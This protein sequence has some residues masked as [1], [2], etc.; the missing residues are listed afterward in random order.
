VRDD[1]RMDDPVEA[2]ASVANPGEF[3]ISLGAMLTDEVVIAE[4]LAS[5]MDW[6]DF[7]TGRRRLLATRRLIVATASANGWIGAEAEVLV[8]DDPHHAL[9]AARPWIEREQQLQ[10]GS[11]QDPEGR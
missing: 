11:T 8:D 3:W 5:G 1:G 2:Y 4:A 7:D 9:A 6:P 10:L